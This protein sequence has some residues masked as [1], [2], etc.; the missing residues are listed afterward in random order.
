MATSSSHRGGWMR[1][2]VQQFERKA[3][4][5]LI[6]YLIKL[7]PLERRLNS[8]LNAL[9]QCLLSEVKQTSQIRPVMSAYDPNRT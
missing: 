4:D 3:W 8:H 2:A 1:K 5:R 7:P 9:D 6:D